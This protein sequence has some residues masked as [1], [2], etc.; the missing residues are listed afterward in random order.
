VDET[1]VDEEEEVECF[2]STVLAGDLDLLSFSD[3]MGV[4][5]SGFL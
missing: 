1:G 4:S 2:L 5:F 3:F